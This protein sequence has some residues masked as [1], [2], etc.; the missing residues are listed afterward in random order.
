MKKAFIF[1]ASAN[2][3]KATGKTLEYKGKA[4]AWT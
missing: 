1:F 3:N 4:F 2:S